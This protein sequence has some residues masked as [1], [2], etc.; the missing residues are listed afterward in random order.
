MGKPGL[1]ITFTVLIIAI[2]GVCLWSASTPR[3]P[4]YNGKPI[5]VWLQDSTPYGVDSPDAI[6]ALRHI[7]INAIPTL[8]R[9]LRANDSPLK[10]KCIELL[11]RQ[12]SV[13]IKIIPAR[14][15][16]YQAFLGFDSLGADA[17][18]A[19]AELVAIYAEKISADSQSY[20]AC[21]IG[22]I[23]PA[24]KSA[25]PTL[26]MGLKTTNDYV[27]WNTALALGRIHGEPASVV[28]E[29][30]RLLDNSNLTTRCFDIQ[31]LGE[32]GTNAESAVPDL[33]V[34]LN[35][36]DPNIRVSATNALKQIDPEAAAKAGVK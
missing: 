15:K 26:L 28:P 32:F 5:S 2:L 30:M 9:M 12:D 20:T 8:L 21:A 6:E 35:D 11:D 10:T 36:Q 7:G 16:N 17:T 25:I 34:M 27:R 22:A 13:R 33:T 19:V 14:D 24:A 23:G 29:L 4:S 31:A 3:E 1:R 18:N